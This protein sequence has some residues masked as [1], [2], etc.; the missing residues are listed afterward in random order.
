MGRY[1]YSTR[2]LRGLLALLFLALGAC[3]SWSY[4]KK[5]DYEDDPLNITPAPDFEDD[6]KP[7]S[8]K[9]RVPQP[10]PK[11]TPTRVMRK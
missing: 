4:V 11:S 6:P 5:E 1:S 9:V 3:E 10:K 2:R 7:V 8:S